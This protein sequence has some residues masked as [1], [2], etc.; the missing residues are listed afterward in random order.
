MDNTDNTSAWYRM[1]PPL[2]YI[3]RYR[4]CA[5]GDGLKDVHRSDFAPL[6]QDD[7]SHGPR[8]DYLQMSRKG[9]APK[10]GAAGGG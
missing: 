10:V 8:S 7:T 3:I 6:P 4:S 9:A 2:S 1:I 5:E